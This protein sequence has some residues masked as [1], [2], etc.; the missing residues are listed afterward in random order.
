[1][2]TLKLSS[3]I[4]LL[5]L[6]LCLIFGIDTAEAGPSSYFHSD[7][8]NTLFVSGSL[9][10][11]ASLEPLIGATILEEG[12]DNGT[13]TDFNGKFE[14]SV[15]KGAI[16]RFSYISYKDQLVESSSGTM[17]VYLAKDAALLDEVVVVGYG[18][19]KKS[20]LTG[21]ISS[22]GAKELKQLPSTGLE[23]ALQGR[24]AGVYITQNSGSPGGA[25]SVRIRGSG[26]TLTTE[27]LYVIDG[28]PISN[29]NAGSSNLR[30]GQGQSTNALTTINP[31][32]IESIE[33]LKDA[34]A[35]AI[36]GSRAANG[37]VIITTKKGTVGETK[38]NYDV[39]TGTQRLYS[40]IPMMSLHNYAE[41]ISEVNFGNI[42]EF[43]NSD[44]LGE[45]T[46]WQE[47]IFRDAMMQNHQISVSD[48][49]E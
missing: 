2:G 17:I 48:G 41:Y 36:Y 14:L 20:D 45:G 10:D 35:T 21:A 46:D 44:L 22:I 4:I 19:Q 49:T 23:Q 15:N 39:Y 16:L 40:E 43:E 47:V 7:Q 42:V 11:K 1:M 31:N 34:S 33:I 37:V 30:D 13:T 9:L 6:F 12:T 8:S 29:D 5:H 25:M 24:S 28:I 27:P 26:S 3:I 32:D 18:S 38:I